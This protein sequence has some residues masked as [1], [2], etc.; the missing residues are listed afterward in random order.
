VDILPVVKVRI[1]QLLCVIQDEG[2]MNQARDDDD[3]D[4]DVIVLLLMLKCFM[5]VDQQ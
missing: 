3:D 2:E 4:D 1:V 5:L